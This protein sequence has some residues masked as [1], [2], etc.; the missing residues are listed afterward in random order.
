VVIQ[1]SDKELPIDTP[2]PMAPPPS[3]KRRKGVGKN[4]FQT[5]LNLSGQKKGRFAKC[6]PTYYNS[7]NLDEPTFQ[8]KKVLFN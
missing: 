8:R 6:E 2:H 1:N 5:F 4:Y 3:A 7:I